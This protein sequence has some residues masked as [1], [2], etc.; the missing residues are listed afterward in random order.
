MM[1]RKTISL[2][3]IAILV[4]FGAGP[5]SAQAIA[6]ADYHVGP[7]Q[8]LTSIGAVPWA[9]L[10]PGDHVYIHWRATPY[11]EKWV[12]C[13]SGSAD[14]PI[15]ISGVPGQGNALPI[16]DG[17]GAITPTNLNYTGEQRGLFKIGSANI[18]DD[19]LPF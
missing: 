10:A 2:L 1:A 8:A 4:G 3:L 19:T 15:T 12:L 7:G 17:S 6:A 13:R 5:A 18:P 14:Q 16:I 11:A 9:T